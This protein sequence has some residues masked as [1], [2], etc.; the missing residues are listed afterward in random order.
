MSNPIIKDSSNLLNKEI[1]DRE[2]EDEAGSGSSY[3]GH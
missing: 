1:S 2:R 3:T